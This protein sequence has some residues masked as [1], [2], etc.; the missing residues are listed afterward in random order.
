MAW[1]VG[2]DARIS[3]PQSVDH[4]YASLGT[5]HW[6]PSWPC[7]Q[8]AKSPSR[9]HDDRIYLVW[10]VRNKAVRKITKGYGHTGKQLLT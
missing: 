4:I 2:V 7:L 8:G 3:L 1:T 6:H 5:L 9:L 10:L